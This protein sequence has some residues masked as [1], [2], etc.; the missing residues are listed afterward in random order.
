MF[1]VY[2]PENLVDYIFMWR[3][4]KTDTR[5][6][7]QFMDNPKVFTSVVQ[8][9]DWLDGFGWYSEFALNYLKKELAEKLIKELEDK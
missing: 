8:L 5:Y 1:R 6:L 7:Y 4:P 9:I 3:N 2:D